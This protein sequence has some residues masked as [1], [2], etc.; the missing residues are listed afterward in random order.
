LIKSG[1]LRPAKIKAGENSKELDSAFHLILARASGNS[2]LY[3]IVN[4]LNDILEESREEL[5][6]S[7]IRRNISFQAHLKIV[8]AVEK[9]DPELAWQEM[10]QHLIGV[11]SIVFNSTEESK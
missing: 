5:Y 4:I 3:K 11:E 2:I 8:E 6:Q 7:A 1:R 10:N 9:Q